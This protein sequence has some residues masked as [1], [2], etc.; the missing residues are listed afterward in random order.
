MML[1]ASTGVLSLALVACSSDADADTE[2]AD[3]TVTATAEATEAT[4]ATATAEATEAT[5]TA[6][7]TEAAGE[8]AE[9]E[10]GAT[11]TE[12]AVELT[13]A[14]A[15][16]GDVTF[17]AEN[18]GALPHEL[19]VVRSDEA[20]DSL[21]LDGAV[22]DESGLDI[23]GRIAEFPASESE[24]GTFTLEAGNYILFCNIAGHYQGG[25]VTA[26]TVE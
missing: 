15:P 18:A 13:A 26:F 11:L 16:A 4:D 20:P 5:A 6:E 24:S 7:A 1:L 19:V 8:A 14:S 17:N 3:A 23:V 12:F 25:M 2:D 22:V 10:I 9:T 21:P